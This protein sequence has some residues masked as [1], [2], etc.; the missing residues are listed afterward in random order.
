MSWLFPIGYGLLGALAGAVLANQTVS[1]W[2]Y[3]LPKLNEMASKKKLTAEF[4]PQKVKTQAYTWVVI[5][6][7]LLGTVIFFISDPSWFIA[8]MAA[9]ILGT[10]MNVKARPERLEKP[11]LQKYQ[12]YFAKK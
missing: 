10:Y 11:F 9:T 2:L 5:T 4:D 3:D 7:F 8:G 1:V 12:K 6:I